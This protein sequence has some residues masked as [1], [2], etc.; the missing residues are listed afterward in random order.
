MNSTP[1]ASKAA[2][3]TVAVEVFGSRFP[4]SKFA[5]VDFETLDALES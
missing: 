1:A 4:S 3:M 5:I 2:T